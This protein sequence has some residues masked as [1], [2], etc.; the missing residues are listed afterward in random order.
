MMMTNKNDT[1]GVPLY[2]IRY[3]CKRADIYLRIYDAQI[4][5][6]VGIYFLK[7][8]KRRHQAAFNYPGHRT[9]D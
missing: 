2:T 6:L 8:E 3:Y 4:V 7:T 1:I 5:K 9:K